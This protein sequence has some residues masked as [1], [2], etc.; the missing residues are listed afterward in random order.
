MVD[1]SDK[2]Q[3]HTLEGI[4]ASVILL[5]AVTYAF[6]A[7]VVTPSSGINPG[8]DTNEQ[9][10][11]DLL[12]AAESNGELKEAVLNWNESTDSFEN[13]TSGT[14][15]YEGDDPDAEYLAFGSYARDA[16]T[17]RGL[18]YNIELGYNDDNGTSTMTMVDKGEPDSSAVTAS[19]TVT[20]NDRDEV[21]NG[22]GNVTLENTTRYPIRKQRDA[23]Y[24]RV[25]VR[26]TVW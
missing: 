3:L 15:Y 10:A 14:Y 25:E 7:F 22:S 19:R 1:R 4:A 2:A 5:L 20:L 23:I 26:I 12:V 16:L 21:M 11:E 24:N 18:S 6:N 17:E 8:T 13:S 9:V